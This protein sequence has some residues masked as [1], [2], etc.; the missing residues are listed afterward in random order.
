M[1]YKRILAPVDGSAASARG[2]KEAIRL[3]R[4]GRARL[5][6]AHVI[7]QFPAI[8]AAEAGASIV[9]LLE[10]LAAAGRRTLARVERAARRAGARPE[11]G[12]IEN[13]GGRVADAIVAEAGRWRADLI[14][15]GTT[16]GAASAVC[17]SAATPS[18]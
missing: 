12:L 4:T 6:L 11:A 3:A 17:C 13:Y 5:R 9:P 10:G 1:A 7:E 15:M 16:G 2:M 18:W 8:G 14:V